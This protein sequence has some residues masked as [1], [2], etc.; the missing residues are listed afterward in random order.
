MINTRIEHDYA[1]D[2]SELSLFYFDTGELSFSGEDVLF[3]GGY[4]QIINNLAKGL[5]I[6]LG[7]R[8][9]T[10]EYNNEG[11]NITTSHGIFK[12]KYVV[13]T[14]SLGV[15]KK[16]DV[17][18][19]P[20]LPDRKVKAIQNLKMG[21]LNRVYLLFP[22][23]FWD[24]DK[25]LIGYIANQKG[26]WAEF[27]NM[28][29]YTGE[30]ILLAFNAGKYGREIENLSDKEIIAS[31]M[32]VLKKIYGDKIPP[33]KDFIITRWGSYEFTGGSYSYTPVGATNDDYDALAEPVMNKVFFA[34]EA[35]NKE[36]HSTVHGAYLSGIREAGKIDELAHKRIN[37]PMIMAK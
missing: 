37:T 16:G 35:T 19:S 7:E 27:Y 12:A 17:K 9:K 4:D 14:I 29:Y 23:V 30:P 28:Y 25:E 22:E 3:P 1:A 2:A 6:R 36:Y 13:C 24:K 8:V 10:V 5:D 31:E 15:L 18:F 11:V 34:R 21:V 26:H 33:P 20:P 32:D